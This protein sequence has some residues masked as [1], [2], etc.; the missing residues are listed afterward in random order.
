MSWQ[1]TSTSRAALQHTRVDIRTVPTSQGGDHVKPMS[2]DSDN[3]S[4][5]DDSETASAVG[6]NIVEVGS[7]ATR[8]G[9]SGSNPVS[10]PTIC[11]RPRNYSHLVGMTLKQVYVGDEVLSKRGLLRVRSM[12]TRHECCRLTMHG[13]WIKKQIVDR[14]ECRCEHLCQWKLHHCCLPSGS[15]SDN[16]Y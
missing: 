6:C 3:C 9:L 7:S 4:T 2:D 13:A 14:N 12:R 11:G 5:D 8:A 1:V 16:Q 15:Q 10:F